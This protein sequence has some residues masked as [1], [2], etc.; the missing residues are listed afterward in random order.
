MLKIGDFAKLARVSVRTL[1][2]YDEIGLLVPDLVDQYS[3][4]RYYAAAQLRRLN[5]IIALQDL[6]F[7]LEQ[8]HELLRE[9]LPFEQLKGMLR[10][11]QAEQQQ[12]VQQ[13]QERLARVAARLAQIEQEQN[14]PAYDVVLKEIPSQLVASVRGFVPGHQA[15][16][17]LFGELFQGLASYQTTGRVS[18][19]PITIWHDDISDEQRM[20]AEALIALNQR[21][22]PAGRMQIYETQPMQVASVVHHGSYQHLSAAYTA[23]VDWIEQQHYQIVGPNWEIYIHSAQ[24]VRQDDPSYVTEILFP[25][26]PQ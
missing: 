2:Y 5:R 12:R 8:I 23:I 19:I 22:P 20:D 15:I 25:I 13:E 11:K 16:G 6:G 18:G 24:P 1:R 7:S 26:Q 3:N 14:P 9:D 17:M 10:L 4:Y 21:L